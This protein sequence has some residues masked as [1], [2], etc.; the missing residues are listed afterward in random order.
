MHSKEAPPC[1]T[2]KGSHRKTNRSLVTPH[3]SYVYYLAEATEK[4]R[5]T[6]SP[7]RIIQFRHD[8]LGACS[9]TSDSVAESTRSITVMILDLYHF[10]SSFPALSLD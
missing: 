7:T 1:V 6:V 2:V 3:T 8:S 5:L 10:T 4:M 9:D